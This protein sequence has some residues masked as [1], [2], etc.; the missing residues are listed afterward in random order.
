MVSSEVP[1]SAERG[2]IL[3]FDR[4][5]KFVGSIAAPFPLRDI[6][7]IKWCQD[8]LWVTCA[9]DDMIAIF[10]GH[11]WSQWYPLG[12]PE[13]E[14][15]DRHHLNSLFFENGKLAVL[16]HD[17]G[18]STI[19]LFTLP[20]LQPLESM[21]LGV[22]AHNIWRENGEYRTCS[23]GE[24]KLVGSECFSV[25]TGGFPRGITCLNQVQCVGVSER[26]ERVE[27]DLTSGKI[28]VF[29]RDWQSQDEIALPNEGLV[30][31]LF[32]Y[33]G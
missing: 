24:G 22:E 1:A 23:S 18:A 26:A 21:R 7:E 32:P 11:S 2:E 14:P 19:H 25:F 28:L 16:A 9:F 5:L 8:R 29:D 4:E 17:W 31:D 6:H 12:P 30:L 3:I 10:D 33:D 27:R 15:R 13:G 20:Y